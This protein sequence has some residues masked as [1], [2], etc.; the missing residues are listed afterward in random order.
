VPL[1]E[2]LVEQ[3]VMV[4]L[5]IMAAVAADLLVVVHPLPVAALELIQALAELMAA[6][7]AAAAAT[8]VVVVVVLAAA[9][10]IAADLAEIVMVLLVVAV[11]LIMQ[12]PVKR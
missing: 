11:V 10:V 8:I 3:E 7:T 5:P 2:L 1:L 6:D 4:D 12:G 9:A